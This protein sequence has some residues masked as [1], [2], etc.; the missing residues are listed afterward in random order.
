MDIN[1]EKWKLLSTAGLRLRSF[2]SESSVLRDGSTR[3]ADKIPAGKAARGMR[4][5]AREEPS[6]PQGTYDWHRVHVTLSE[7]DWSSTIDN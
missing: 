1:R 3:T 5:M 2:F 4:R 7:Y 6:A